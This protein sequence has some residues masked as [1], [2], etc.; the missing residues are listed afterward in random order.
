MQDTEDAKSASSKI[1]DFDGPGVA[2]IIYW[3]G[4]SIETE[5]LYQ[6]NIEQFD[7][8]MWKSVFKNI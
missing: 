8:K 2:F 5:T 6:R 7:Y 3:F 1:F 4:K